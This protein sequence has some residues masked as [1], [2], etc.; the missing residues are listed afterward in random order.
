MELKS[1]FPVLD[2]IL[3]K[4]LVTRCPGFAF[5]SDRELAACANSPM[6][7]YYAIYCG[8]RVDGGLFHQK[9]HVL[10]DKVKMLLA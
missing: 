2:L 3:N 9:F 10:F 6:K 5:N 8:A 4:I 7:L 1:S